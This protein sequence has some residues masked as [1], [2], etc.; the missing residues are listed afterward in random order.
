MKRLKFENLHIRPIT[1]IKGNEPFIF[2][3]EPNF[4]ILPNVRSRDGRSHTFLDNLSGIDFSR[5]Q[6]ADSLHLGLVR[7]S[8]VD[9]PWHDPF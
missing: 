5:L 8:T 9:V 3:L 7:V 6:K 2:L 4:I 1:A